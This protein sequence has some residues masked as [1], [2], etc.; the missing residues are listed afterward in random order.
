MKLWAVELPAA[1][2]AAWRK[3]A[4]GKRPLV[5]QPLV[6]RPHGILPRAQA[7]VAAGGSREASTATAAN[8]T[9]QSAQSVTAEAEFR[10]LTLFLHRQKP[11]IG[12]TIPPL[13]EGA[14]L[15]FDVA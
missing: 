13:S 14:S 8:T 12:Q 10:D 4:D 15:G 6:V 2:I 9:G 3:A 7:P 1:P 11:P 5:A